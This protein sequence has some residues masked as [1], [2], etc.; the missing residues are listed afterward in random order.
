[1]A[2]KIKQ[3]FWLLLGLVA[4]CVTVY[5][6]GYYSHQPEAKTKLVPTE[7]KLTVDDVVSLIEERNPKIDPDLRAIIARNVLKAGEKYKV[8]P[9]LLLGQI[10]TES[11]WDP[12]RKGDEGEMGLM[13]LHPVYQ[14]EAIK[15]RGYESYEV[16]HIANNV[17]L[18]AAYLKENLNRFRG[19]VVLALSAYNAGPTAT[20]KAGD[21]PSWKARE[22]VRKTLGIYAQAKNRGW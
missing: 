10:D 1:M 6:V 17:D 22:Y 2:N 21:C 5:E 15:A 11:T 3:A 20:E 8:D 14:A 13:Q 9:A 16:Y 19:N 4:L 18:G 7:Y 12:M